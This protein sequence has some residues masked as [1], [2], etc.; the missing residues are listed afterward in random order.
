[1]TVSEVAAYLR[2]HDN[3]LIL[4][5]RR[6]DGDTLG[7]AAALCAMLR[8]MGKTAGVLYNRE[9]TGHFEPYVEPYWVADDSIE[10]GAHILELLRDPRVVKPRTPK[11]KR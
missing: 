7:C 11:T 1:M 4:T 10:Y 9:T 6:P 2:A 5:H 8:Q 3:Y